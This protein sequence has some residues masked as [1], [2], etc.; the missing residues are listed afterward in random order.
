MCRRAGFDLMPDRF[1][2]AMARSWVEACCAEWD[3]MEICDDLALATSELVTNA[4]LHARTPLEIEACVAEGVVEAQV[5]DLSPLLPTVLPMRKDLA[6]DIEVLLSSLHGP[7]DDDLRHTS[8]VV[9]SAGSIAAGRGLHLLEAVTDC[10]GVSLLSDEQGKVVWFAVAV[11][12]HWQP[13]EACSCAVAGECTASGRPV[14]ASSSP[15]SF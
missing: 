12:A 9:G 2:P 1:S 8:W 5:L 10:W 7:E 15:L 6:A 13:N 14:R 11:P 3:L 4:V